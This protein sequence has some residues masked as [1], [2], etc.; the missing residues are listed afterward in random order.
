MLQ[1]RNHNP[2]PLRS[3]LDRAK[4]A[5]NRSL[6]SVVR[7]VSKDKNPDRV[8]SVCHRFDSNCDKV[9]TIMKAH[10]Q[11]QKAALNV[12]DAVEEYLEDHMAADR[13]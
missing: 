13:V 12:L 7:S 5:R 3:P 10:Q 2:N 1:L 11:V 6:S 4:R 9:V 8:R